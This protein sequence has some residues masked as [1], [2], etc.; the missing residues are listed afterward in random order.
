MHG[1]YIIHVDGS[2]PSGSLG[3]EVSSCFSGFPFNR[4][5]GPSSDTVLRFW[6]FFGGPHKVD[7]SRSTLPTQ[8]GPTDVGIPKFIGLTDRI[9]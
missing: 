8:R 4:L 2:E 1:L 6:E 9:L 3:F 5:N 7:E